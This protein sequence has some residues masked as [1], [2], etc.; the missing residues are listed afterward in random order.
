MGGIL[1]TAPAF[2]AVP[3]EPLGWY[4]HVPFCAAK[5]RYCDFY[6]IPVDAELVAGYLD[7]VRRE[8][9][10][11]AP[12]R[13][14]ASVFV[15]GGT[16]T[17]LPEPVLEALLEAAAGSAASGIEF[18]VEA[19]PA[20]TA[21]MKLRT[22]RRLGVNRLSLGVQSFHA[23]ELRLLG[24]VHDPGQIA[25]SF[26]AARGVGFENINL[27]LIYGTPG[28]TLDRWG[29][30]LRLAVEL[31]PE[32]L[33]CYAL[34]YE[35]GTPMARLRD[36]G[37][38]TPCDEEAE[39]AMFEAAVER[40]TAAGYEHYEISNFARPGRRCLANMIYW[41]NCEY[42]GIGPS[43]VSYLDGVRRKNVPDVRRYIEAMK[44]SP[45]EAVIEEETLSP[46]ARAC[47][48]AIQ[49]LRLTEGIDLD[50]FRRRTGF[51]AEELFAEQVGR[52]VGEGLLH[53]S[54]ASIRLTR[55][56]L[57]LAN[58]VMADFAP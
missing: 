39:A 24:R 19:N 46:R 44:S 3:V 18:T 34:T 6:S 9:S 23:D 8:L 37:A 52:F 31:N 5:C 32:H 12:S 13:P 45:D 38:I 43:A 25:A 14:V 10:I 11:R 28:Q 7:A 29:E 17:V 4:F 55:R 2:R 56:G 22:L 53:V 15:G 36:R 48:T 40:L 50:E 58:L 1:I 27:D 21:D 30:S 33:S 16:P 49:M 41:K 51:A 47:E 57:L 54:P 26:T 20:S 42:L 35:P